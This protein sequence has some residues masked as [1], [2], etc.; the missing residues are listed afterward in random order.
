MEDDLTRPLGTEPH[1]RR[2]PFGISIQKILATI[3]T[4]T[5]GGFVLWAVIGNHQ[6]SEPGEVVKIE[7]RPSEL[8][9]RAEPH[10]ESD[11]SAP[12]LASIGSRTSVD[13][14]KPFQRVPVNT[15]TVTI[16]DGKTGARQEVIIPA[17]DD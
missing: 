17:T 12:G 13:A 15:K 1:P 10:P 4:V 5:L 9:G 8:I 2:Q 11:S 3:A 7:V 6:S 14:A 16:I